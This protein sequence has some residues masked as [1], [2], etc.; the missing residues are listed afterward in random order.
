ML[1]ARSLTAEDGRD[2]WLAALLRLLCCR[3]AAKLPELSQTL[4]DGLRRDGLDDF[5]RRLA[6]LTMRMLLARFGRE[7]EV[8]PGGYLDQALRYM[9]EP[10][11]LERAITKW[12]NA[13]LAEGLQKGRA[14]G[15]RAYLQ[16]MAAR[17]F[18]GAAGDALAALLGEATDVRR[19]DAIGDLVSDCT[20][21]DELLRR[22]GGVLNGRSP[23]RSA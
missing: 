20:S 10:T 7:Q 1:D 12:R 11:M 4:F 2:N 23:A 17:R 9:E 6:D 18:G 3:D 8:R 19:L 5:A 16:R 13:A 14:E 21:A 15:Q 22:S